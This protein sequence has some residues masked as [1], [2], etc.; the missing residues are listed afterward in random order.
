ML[1]ASNAT[2]TFALKTCLAHTKATKAKTNQSPG[3]MLL[4]KERLL[5]LSTFRTVPHVPRL[6]PKAF[7]GDDGGY[8][9][10]VMEMLGMTLT[11]KLQ[12]C[13]GR[14]SLDAVAYVGKCVVS[15]G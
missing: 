9:F 15:R 1:A 6:A 12:Q 10:L 2:G 13:G 14:L 5:Y 11:E 8:R 3:A 7:Y 4:F